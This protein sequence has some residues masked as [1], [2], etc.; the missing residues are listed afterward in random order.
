MAGH[1]DNRPI[2][3]RGQ[4]DRATYR[5]VPPIG[6][7][8]SYAAKDADLFDAVATELWQTEVL[9]NGKPL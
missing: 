9:R 1:P 6:R 2:W 7:R 5:L 4:N 3:Y 8:W